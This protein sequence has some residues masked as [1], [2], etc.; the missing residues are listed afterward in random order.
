MVMRHR[1]A[2]RVGVPPVVRRLLRRLRR[3]AAVYRPSPTLKPGR[4]QPPSHETFC[5]SFGGDHPWSPDSVSM[6][7]LHRRRVVPRDPATGRT[8]LWASRSSRGARGPGDPFL[9]RSGDPAARPRARPRDLE[10]VAPP[11]ARVPSATRPPPVV[12][13]SRR[14]RQLLR[15]TSRCSSR[16]RLRLLMLR[17]T[18][19]LCSPGR[20]RTGSWHPFCARS[21]R[22]RVI[23]QLSPRARAR[24]LGAVRLVLCA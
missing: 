13:R 18:R 8:I 20:F 2:C 4:P 5:G 3:P 7:A 17:P 22:A 12:S 23:R 6:G 14:D 24:R 11:G 16:G 10:I 19:D 1:A 15:L 9:S 21:R